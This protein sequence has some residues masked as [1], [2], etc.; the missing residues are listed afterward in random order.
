MKHPTNRRT[1]LLAAA[2]ATLAAATLAAATRSAAAQPTDIHGAVRFAGGAVI[3]AG[4]IEIYL[5]NPAIQDSAER[6]VAA[7]R[8]Q[9]DGGSKTLD[10]FLPQP[11]SATAAPLLRIVA[12]LTRQDGWLLAR[13]SAVLKIGVPAD[14]TLNLA[15]Y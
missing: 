2:A 3:P 1:L 9:S 10:F 12:R 11:A 8:L 5:E 14:I 15:V 7:T 6:R 4:Q 13:G